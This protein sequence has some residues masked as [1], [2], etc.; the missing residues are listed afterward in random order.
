MHKQTDDA[1]MIFLSDRGTLVWL[2]ARGN[3]GKD[4]DK[5]LNVT[6]FGRG[7]GVFIKSANLGCVVWGRQ[8][9][10]KIVY[11]CPLELLTPPFDK[12]DDDARGTG[13][14]GKG[15]SVSSFEPGF[16]KF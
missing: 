9:S 14:S 13:Y 6:S 8:P 4:Y 1:T 10:Q 15:T 16:L 7:T 11:A 2:V 12:L 3:H 5:D